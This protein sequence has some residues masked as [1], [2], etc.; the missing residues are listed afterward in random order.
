MSADAVVSLIDL[1]KSYQ[2]GP[3]YV[4]ALRGVTF[5]VM[6][7]EVVAVVGP[8]GSGKTT[9]LNVIAGWE[10][11]DRGVVTWAG[12]QAVDTAALHWEDIGIVPQRLG[13]LDDLTANENIELPLVL[14]GCG[15]ADAQARVTEVISSLDIAHVADR[16]PLETSLGEQQRIAVGRALALVPT[17]ILADEPTGNQD[18]KRRAVVMTALRVAADSGSSCVVATHDRDVIRGC[19]RV[20]TLH[21]GELVSDE[22]TGWN[23][24]LLHKERG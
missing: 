6:Q 12:E 11:P 16:L 20:I 13:L 24:W 22:A 17:L 14:A 18:K 2:R 19:D 4:I 21:D 3:E 10:R 15:Q 23:P 7:G 1:H 9:L 8:S 5:E